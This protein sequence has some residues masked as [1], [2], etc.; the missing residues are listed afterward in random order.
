MQR[1]LKKVSVVIETDSTILL[2]CTLQTVIIPD[3]DYLIS[4]SL[5]LCGVIILLICNQSYIWYC[6]P[7]YITTH[8]IGSTRGQVDRD[9]CIM[10]YCTCIKALLQILLQPYEYSTGHCQ[11]WRVRVIFVKPK[12]TV[13]L[14][15][16][17]MILH[18]HHWKTL[19]FT[20]GFWCQT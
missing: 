2:V 1:K 4:E 5:F 6:R 12:S 10:V 16:T 20:F 15:C 3:V 17:G 13:L 14:V 18:P 11:K 8:V 7:R 19:S 9:W